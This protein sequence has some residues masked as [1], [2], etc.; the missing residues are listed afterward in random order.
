MSHDKFVKYEEEELDRGAINRKQMLDILIQKAHFDAD[1]RTIEKRHRG[2]F[3][4]FMD[5]KMYVK[6]TLQEIL[7][8]SKR[9]RPVYFEPVGFDLW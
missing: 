3:V 1:R 5:G 2:R 9:G 8:V 7:S 6:P 4:G